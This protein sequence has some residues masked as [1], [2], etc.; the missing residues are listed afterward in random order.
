MLKVD[1]LHVYY[2]GI[3]ALKGVSIDINSG[4]I[5][6]IIGANGAGKSTLLNAVSGFLKYKEGKITYKGENLTSNPSKVVKDGICQ[7]PE[8]RLVFANLSVK[9][10]LYLGA[11]LRNDNKKIKE[12]LE[13][14]YT[15][16]PRL[17]ER[18]N[19]I[20]GTL[21][22][23]EQQML[24]MG[25]GLMSNPDLMLLDEPSLG[26]A[27][28]LVQTVFDIIVDIRKMGKTILLV[29]QNAYKALSVADRAYV[30]EQGKITMKGSA[31]EIAENPNIK[32]AYLGTAK[33][34]I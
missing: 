17:K 18:E 9:D 7:V 29:E 34:K 27:P 3:H 6:T 11:Y 28:L 26:L 5:V 15:L 32:S 14:V 33:Q 31:K 20:A 1:N 24:A 30:L 8:G 22:G 13:K 16:F 4:E 21:S 23:G 19:Q 10:N 12:D 25:R 2:G